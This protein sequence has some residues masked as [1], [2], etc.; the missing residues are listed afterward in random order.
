MIFRGRAFHAEE[1]AVQILWE[2]VW[3][4]L[5]RAW[6]SVWLEQSKGIIGGDEVRGGRGKPDHVG[7]CWPLGGL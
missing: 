4:V 1:R 2:Y 3:H 5:G 7:L 6:R